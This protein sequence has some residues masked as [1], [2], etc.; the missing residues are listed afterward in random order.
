M[1]IKQPTKTS[2]AEALASLYISK[3]EGITRDELNYAVKQDL[4]WRSVSDVDHG[5]FMAMCR[6]ET[7]RIRA[8]PSFAASRF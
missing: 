3:N 4:G 5:V 7:R 2:K 6:D 8:R 1:N